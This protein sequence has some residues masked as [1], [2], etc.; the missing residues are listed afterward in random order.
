MIKNEILFEE[1]IKVKSN[2]KSFLIIL[3]G[4]NLSIF[5]HLSFA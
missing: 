2:Q 3:L 4:E 1:K 5:S